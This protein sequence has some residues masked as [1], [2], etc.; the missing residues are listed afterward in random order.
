MSYILDN[1]AIVFGLLLEHLWITSAALVVAFVI[2]L[3]LGVVAARFRRFGALL[4]GALGVLYTIPSLAL[5][6]FLVPIFGLNARSVIVALIVYA[7]IILVRNI[8]A[9]LQA[10]DAAVLDVA[11]GMGMS[12]WQRW[13][14]VQWPLALPVVL[15]GVRLAAIV[16]IGIATIGAKFSAG[17][18]GRLLFD[19]I[20]QTERYDKIWAGAIAIA[21]LAFT[22]NW[23]LGRAERVSGAHRT[24][25]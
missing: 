19:G 21:A 17:G 5:I 14:R 1:P 16:C 2:A 9:G 18:L 11:R 15:A 13:R 3:P 12:A 7:Q 25:V 8:T 20:A 4:V 23:A 22:A 6:I 24:I 10:V